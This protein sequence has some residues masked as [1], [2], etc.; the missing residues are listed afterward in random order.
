MLSFAYFAHDVLY[1][2]P[3]SFLISLFI[4][5][6]FHMYTVNNIHDCCS[7]AGLHVA[8][9]DPRPRRRLPLLHSR[10][11]HL[12]KL[13]TWSSVHSK[14]VVLGAAAHYNGLGGH[15][16]VGDT[17]TLRAAAGGEM[18][19]HNYVGKVLAMNKSNVV[20]MKCGAAK[21][22]YDSN[23]YAADEKTTEW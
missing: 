23:N 1:I 10:V 2:C 14:P 21:P 4:Y 18:C 15:V 17:G 12:A 6:Y 13:R 7:A 20:N 22:Y 3:E 11:T 8:G 5:D 19:S 16:R 9:T